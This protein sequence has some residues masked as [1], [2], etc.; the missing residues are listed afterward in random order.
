[1]GILLSTARADAADP[2]RLEAALRQGGHRV[3]RP[4]LVIWGALGA[5]EHLSPAELLRRARAVEP[6]IGLSTV[7]RT[8]RLFIDAGLVRGAHLGAAGQRF[9]RVEGGH[10]DHL[11]CEGCG[12][13]VELALCPVEPLVGAIETQTAFRV[14]G[15]YLELYGTCARCAG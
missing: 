6:S 12:E 7:Y 14:R 8:L 10:H 15:H 13:T 1:M 11:L 4:R 2:S 5:G 3:T 9:A